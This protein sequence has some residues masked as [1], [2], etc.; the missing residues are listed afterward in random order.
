MVHGDTSQ[1]LRY[2]CAASD[3]GVAVVTVVGAAVVSDVGGRV[4][5][6]TGVTVVAVSGAAVV[7]G[8]ATAVGVVDGSPE[9]LHSKN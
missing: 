1:V 5:D 3:C 8:A 7:S 2:G 6:V 4:V 9:Q